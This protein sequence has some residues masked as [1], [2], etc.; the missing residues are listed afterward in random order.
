MKK[1]I[2]G[3][4]IFIF[5]SFLCQAQEISLRKGLTITKSSKIKKGTY[6]LDGFDSL[7]KPVIV[8]EGNNITVDFN[9][10]VLKGSNRKQNPDDFFGVAIQIK[11]GR[12]ITIKNLTARGY[13]VALVAKNIEGLKIENC[14]FSYNYRQHLNS[15][16]E[17]EDISDWMSYHQNENDEW[18]R[19][20]AAMYLRGCSNVIVSNCKVTGGQNALMMMECNNGMIY[21]NNFSFNSG[22]G[23]GMYKC[24]FNKVLYNKINF[25]VRGYSHGVYNRGQDS[26]GILVYEQSNNNLFYKNSVTHGGDGFFLWAGQTTMDTGKGGCNDNILM[27][28]D[29]SYAPTNGIEVTFSRNKII[30]NRI[31]ECDHGIW[32]GY[33]FDT[34]ISGNQFRYNRIAIAIE[35]G[36]NNTIHHNLF[37][38]DKEAIRLW[39][40]KEQPSDWGYAKYRDT[41]SANYVIAG[42]S[43][44]K[45]S[46]VF[47]LSRTDSLK[48]FD[49]RISLTDAVYKADST[50]TSFDTTFDEELIYQLSEEYKPGIPVVQKPIE[51][52]KGNGKFAGRK[53]IMIT[54]WGP[55]D[56]GY[57]IVWNTNPADTSGTMEFDLL[58]PKGKWKIVSAKGLE[59]ISLKNGNLPTKITAQKSTTA[60]TDIEIVAEFVGEHF[61]D[62]FGNK[63]PAKKAYRFSFKKFFQPI[64]FNISWYSFDS[65]TNPINTN[66]LEQLKTQ[67][68]FKSESVN[69]LDYAWWGGIKA[70]EEQYRQFL[71]VAEGFAEIPKGQ[72]ELSITWDDAV[73]VYVDEKLVI[74]EWNPSK[75]KFD[76]S[77]HR[78]IKLA[79]GGNHNFRVEH[80]ELGG[81]ATLA[82]KLKKIN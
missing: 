14:D 24:S 12:N 25:N 16:Q 59:N 70:G 41:R 71:T 44:N 68:P 61:T 31:F 79:L 40:R 6:K 36:L 53:N 33:S 43:F 75:Y 21:N 4:F 18:L 30:H 82:L 55:Y 46:L 56:F 9:N 76:E 42:N 23:L 3:I 77:P 73:R 34:E 17:K 62:Q 26:A 49:N 48:I 2:A 57:P 35:H 38:E 5:T 54:E 29:F 28:N 52:F 15:T 37:Y 58:G 22:I 66:Y 1:S 19:Y 60:G 72:Y 7:N 50:V 78:K 69:K 67:R 65:S 39:S 74:D 32:G 10:V 47:N 20:G 45:N 11:N 80:V 81:F 63:R 13:K 51:P 27:D 64:D 8:I